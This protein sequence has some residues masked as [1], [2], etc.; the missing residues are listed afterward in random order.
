M[1]LVYFLLV[2]FLSNTIIA[3]INKV[4]III[5]STNLSEDVSVVSTKNDE[6]LFLV[7]EIESEEYQS[8]LINEYFVLDSSR[9]EISIEA[10]LDKNRR[11]EYYLLEM[12]SHR[13]YLQLDPIIRIHHKAIKECFVKGDYLGIEKYLEDDDILDINELTMPI[14]KSINSIYKIDRYS[15]QITM[16]KEL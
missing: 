16:N 7:Y 13:D 9:M 11:Y 4:E 15:Y 12:D 14:N 5:S 8:P 6:V 1:K 3:Q 10:N 2:Y